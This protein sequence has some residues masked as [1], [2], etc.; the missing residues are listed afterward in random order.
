MNY[1]FFSCVYQK[2]AVLLSLN[3]IINHI[4]VQFMNRNIAF[5]FLIASLMLGCTHG[6]NDEEREMNTFIDNLMGRMT[7][8]EKLGQLSAA[9]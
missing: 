2:K 8:E 3:W 1:V 5:V 6:V 9:I 4:L 7:L